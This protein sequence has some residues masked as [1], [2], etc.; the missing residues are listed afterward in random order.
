MLVDY[1]LFA[2]APS[3]F[4][5]YPVRLALNL[6]WM[7]ARYALLSAEGGPY[8]EPLTSHT[9]LTEYAVQTIVIHAVRLWVERQMLQKDRSTLETTGT[10]DDDSDL[11]VVTNFFRHFDNV[12][13][14]G[15][16]M[17]TVLAG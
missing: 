6:L 2:I 9:T 12:A 17:S 5:W 3:L 15:I 14:I 13:L 11:A 7:S 4:L 10:V 8:D 16:P 1:I